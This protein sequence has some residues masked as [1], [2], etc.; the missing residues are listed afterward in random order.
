M[1]KAEYLA[2]L[3]RRLK[4]LPESERQDA[5]DYYKGYLDDAPGQGKKAMKELGTPAEVA[6]KIL[7]EF[8]IKKAPK[9]DESKKKGM[10]TTLAVILAVFAAPIGLPLAIAVFT[11][12]FALLITLI[13][14]IVSFG[15]SGVAMIL[16]GIAYLPIAL[17]VLIQDGALGLATLGAGAF[18]LGLGMVFLGGAT[19]LARV[20]FGGIA[21]FV[22]K[23]IL[24]DKESK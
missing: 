15:A 12:A 7:A 5:L 4:A 1:D 21:N 6:A 3:E 20:G 13:A 23:V 10:S 22:G 18:S 17:I 16:A 24:K 14:L 8:S 11:V 9:T 19:V 2:E